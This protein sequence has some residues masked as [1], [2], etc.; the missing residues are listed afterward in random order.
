MSD[1]LPLPSRPNLEQYRNLARDL[2]RAVRSADPEK[3]ARWASRW[4][5]DVDRLERRLREFVRSPDR[6]AA[7]KLTDAQFF[8]AREHGF[9]SWPAFVAHLE[10]LTHDSSP[11]ALFESAVEAIRPTAERATSPAPRSREGG[12]TARRTRRG[13]SLRRARPHRT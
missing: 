10:G 3:L 12:P 1:A 13:R 4:P 6:A 2:Q 8:V 7:F 5:S 9:A 11:V